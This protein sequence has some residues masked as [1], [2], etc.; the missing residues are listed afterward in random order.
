MRRVR[1]LD[2]NLSRNQADIEA[3][4]REQV[5]DALTVEFGCEYCQHTLNLGHADFD[6]LSAE[7]I[8]QDMRNLDPKIDTTPFYGTRPA[9]RAIRAW[10]VVNDFQSHTTN[11]RNGLMVKYFTEYQTKG[12]AGRR[13][14]T[15]KSSGNFHRKGVDMPNKKYSFSWDLQSVPSQ[16]QVDGASELPEPAQTTSLKMVSELE[17]ICAN[18]AHSNVERQPSF[19]VPG[20]ACA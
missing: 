7:T 6:K 20:R 8:L 18:E 3:D 12:R 11:I 14:C 10:L 1:V 17:E 13:A 4:K 19:S 2:K 15:G 5:I 9:F 16:I